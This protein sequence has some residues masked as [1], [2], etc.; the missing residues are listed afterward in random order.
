MFFTQKVTENTKVF[1]HYLTDHSPGW[2]PL[3]WVDLNARLYAKYLRMWYD[4][5]IFTAIGALVL[6]TYLAFCMSP[7]GKENWVDFA[8]FIAS[9][10]TLC[11][12]MICIAAGFSMTESAPSIIKRMNFQTK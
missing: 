9:L 5:I 1:T 2:V 12:G 8:F 11:T 4:G 10:P 7:A 3:S 6:V